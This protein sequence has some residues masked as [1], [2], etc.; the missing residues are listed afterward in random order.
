MTNGIITLIAITNT[1]LH[2]TN[3][4]D[5]IT[6]PLCRV[7]VPQPL[8]TNAY[9]ISGGLAHQHDFDKA[10][11]VRSFVVTRISGGDFTWEGQ[12]RKISTITNVIS[13]TETFTNSPNWK[14]TTPL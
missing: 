5:Q 12:P 14:S 6:Y 7:C 2:T 4:S 10:V 11:R 9:W 1:V 13:V 8:T 3:I